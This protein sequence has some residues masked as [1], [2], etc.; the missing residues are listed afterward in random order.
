MILCIDKAAVGQ[1]HTKNTR[2]TLQRQKAEA[3]YFASKQILP[4]GFAEGRRI[5]CKISNSNSVYLCLNDNA[6]MH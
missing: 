3:A 1:A 4:F 2:T 5:K 6:L